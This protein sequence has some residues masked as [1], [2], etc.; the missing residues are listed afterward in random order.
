MVEVANFVG[1][2]R[3]VLMVVSDI[4]GE[5]PVIGKDLLSQQEVE[6]LNR[7]RA[8]VR[9]VSEAAGNLVESS[10]QRAVASLLDVSP[11]PHIS[12]PSSLSLSLST[13]ISRW[14]QCVSEDSSTFV[15]EDQR[16]PKAELSSGLRCLHCSG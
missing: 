4:K 1:S 12:L 5:A 2:G 16:S 15:C 13:Q 7:G 3:D 6:D 11:H 14:G 10:V 9:T 8:F